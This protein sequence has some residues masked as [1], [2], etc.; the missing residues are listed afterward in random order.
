[1]Q[2][3]IRFTLFLALIFLSFQGLKA[4]DAFLIGLVLNEDS[5]PLQGASVVLASKEGPTKKGVITS[6]RGRFRFQ[7]Q[8]PG[9]YRLEISLVGYEPFVKE[10]SLTA[11]PNFGGRIVLGEKSY[12]L[13]QVVIEGQVP[14]AQQKG[15]TTEYN[16]D[17]FK[18]NP[19]ANAQNLLEKMPGVVVQ[20]GEVQA[21][22]ERVQQVLVDGKRFFGDDPRAALQNLPAE[23]IQKIQVF[24]QQ[25]EQAQQTGFDDGETVKTINIV[26]RPDMRNYTIGRIYGGIGVED[27]EQSRYNSG[28]NLNI[29]DDAQRISIL[30]QVNNINQQNFATEDLLG[31]ISSNNS[32]GGRR[33]RRGRG[34]PGGGR[35]GGDA[36]DFLI[37]EQGGIAT[38]RAFGINYSDNWGK[39]IEVSAS[40]FFNQNDQIN[41][42]LLRQEY[43]S[44]GERNQIYTEDEST[45]S[46]NLNHRLNM[47]M[48]F[49]I[50]DRSSL[51]FR[52]ALT[53]QQNEG[54]STTLSETLL[55]SRLQSSSASEFESDLQALS[56]SNLLA[57]RH[58]FEKRG[59]SI[60]I[61]SRINY[62][63]QSGE[64]LL[65]SDLVFGNGY[66]QRDSIDQQGLL[67]NQGLNLFANVRYTEPLGKVGM[68]QLY[69]QYGPQFNDSDRRTL[70]QPDG[71]EAYSLIDTS[72]SNTFENQYSVHEGG[73][74]FFLRGKKA[75]FISRLGYQYAVLDNESTFPVDEDILR[76]FNSLVPFA[77]LRYNFSRSNS[78]RI[79]YRGS[80]NPPSVQ[81]LQEVIDNSN[82]LQVVSGNPELD[83]S[84]SHRFILRYNK[85]NTSKNRVFIAFL[86]ATSTQNYVGQHTI[87]P[88]QDSS[89]ANGFFLP[90]GSQYTF[91]VNLDGF[92]SGRAFVSTGKLFERLKVNVNIDASLNYQR[93]PGLIDNVL[94]FSNTTTLGLGLVISSNISEKVDFTLSSR[95]NANQVVNS[96]Q[97]SQNT[98]FLQQTSKA[99]VNLIFG[100]NIVFRSA[101]DHQ[102]FA[103]LSEDFNQNFWLWSLGLAKK[104]L[105]NDQAE[106]QISTFDA[107]G[108]NNSIQRTVTDNYIE[109]LQ[110]L[111][112]QRY[113]MLT[114]TYNLRNF[115]PQGNQP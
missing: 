3:P 107:L 5:L 2:I 89:L 66:G 51:I 50:S 115:S 63:E 43:I 28:G 85:T 104:F 41:E 16:S 100:P 31:V 81:E 18:T 56:T 9:D 71:S 114:F 54:S 110:T 12:E 34:G 58:R 75:F 99:R 106:I 101:L 21:Q 80:T 19:D 93:L 76:D 8:E 112:L 82:P 24:D 97:S 4:Q 109:D 113:F 59:R 108:Q 103:G 1:M 90:A 44:G 95:T 67:S 37:N 35:N 78:L 83:Q 23:I 40:Y 98:N 86:N 102:L 88:Q 49:K 6:S 15:D 111:V 39:K 64:N 72:L 94:N 79:I 105:K 17:A 25:S 7:E 45:L 32:R 73:A 96:V 60:S 27:E 68:L 84:Y 87:R 26:T 42:S 77:L 22:G 69:Y 20:N 29:F 57:F 14:P 53:L 38:T 61:A 47:R 13:E 10:I 30:G 91:P 55:G 36:S 92:F 65:L 52:P 62:S 74:G 48:E 46:S 70:V 11:G 33:G